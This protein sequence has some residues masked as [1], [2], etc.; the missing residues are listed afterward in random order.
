MEVFLEFSSIVIIATIV[1]VIMRILKQPLVVGYI[2]TGIIVGPQLFDVIQTTEYLEL[3]SKIGIAIL[4]FIVGLSLSPKVIKDVGKVSL[5]SGL[6]QVLFTSLIG[7]GIAIML[8]FSLVSSLYIS[9]ALT[10]SSTIIILKLLSDKGDLQKLYGKIAIGFLLVQDIVATFILMTVSSLSGADGG[11]IVQILS[12]VFVKGIVLLGILYLITRY[13]IPSAVHYLAHS[14]ELLFMFAIAWALGLASVFYVQD[15]SIE[16]GALIAG[17]TMSITPFAD[18]IASRLRP[19]R[20]FFIVL[21]FILLGS[22]MILDEIPT[23]ILPATIFSVFVLVGNPLIVAVLMNLLGYKRRIG[24]QAGLTVAQISEF[25]LILAALGLTAGHIDSQTVSLITLVGLITI[26]GSTYLILYSDYIYPKVEWLLALLE[27]RKVKTMKHAVDKDTELLLFGYD[28]VG[29]DFVNAF[30]K[31]EKKY[32]VIDF[33]PALIKHLEEQ[34][35]PHRY[36]DAQ[37]VEF[38]N[39][40]NL[41]TLKMCISTIPYVEVNSLL[42]KKIRSHNDKTIIIVRARHI[43]EAKELYDLGASY[44]VMPHYLGAKYATAMISRIGLDTK[45]FDDERAKHQKY[46]KSLHNGI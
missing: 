29:H 38:L 7:F 20:D 37:D 9:I 32:M 21:F 45:G 46:I 6:G 17:V 15:F 8:G 18:G 2:F 14:Q 23:I 30:K 3:F 39:E 40:L 19:I 35:I 28:R 41:S 33:N 44:V 24:F 22:E 34:H 4:L 42:V 43:H 36:G 31:L 1:S 12:V 16:V 10:F 13:L 11:N 25:S 5:V 27:F 26:A